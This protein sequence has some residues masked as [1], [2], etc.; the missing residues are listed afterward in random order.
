MGQDPPNGVRVVVSAPP[1]S[2]LYFSPSGFPWSLRC[3]DLAGSGGYRV[4]AGGPR[5]SAGA[6]RTE[7]RSGLT[8]CL[9]LLLQES[10]ESFTVASSPARRRRSNDPLTSSPGRSSRRTDALTSSP[11]RDLPPFEDESEGLLGT[12]GPLEEEEDGEELIGE[13]MERYFGPRAWTFSPGAE[14]FAER[15]GILP[16]GDGGRWFGCGLVRGLWGW[17][18]PTQVLEGQG[19]KALGSSYPPGLQEGCQPRM[20]ETVSLVF[21]D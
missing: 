21:H 2:F 19:L 4:L 15:T 10:S 11:G 20:M 9:R 8:H 17:H 18:T 12:E 5:C 14:S 16:L 7:A 6:A 13:G 1:L 3:K